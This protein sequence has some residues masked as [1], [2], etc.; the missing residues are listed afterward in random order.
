MN[1]FVTEFNLIK[2]SIAYLI[3]AYLDDKSSDYLKNLLPDYDH[4]NN[5]VVAASRGVSILVSK[6]LNLEILDTK[7]GVDENFICIQCKIDKKKHF[8]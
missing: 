2:P 6:S 5:K 4:Y 1:K 3:D 8:Y 7:T